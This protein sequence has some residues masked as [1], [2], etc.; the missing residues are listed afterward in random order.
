M[1]HIVIFMK[2]PS[3]LASTVVKKA[4]EANQKNLFPD[5]E[6]LQETL[7]QAAGKLSEDG[8]RIL[9]VTLVKEGKLE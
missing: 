5:D 8:I 3:H 4:I 6:S 1:P 9:S 2:Y 7:V